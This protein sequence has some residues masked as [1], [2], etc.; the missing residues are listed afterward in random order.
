[1]NRIEIAGV[2]G[3]ILVVV[4]VAGGFTAGPER[5]AVIGFGLGLAFDLLLSTPLGLTALVYTAVGYVAGL[6]ATALIR[7]TKL[8]V[9][10]LATLAAPMA[11]FIWVVVGAL[12][13]QTHLFEGPLLAIA[14]VGAVVAFAS[15]WLIAPA[16]Q[17]A[18]FDLDRQVRRY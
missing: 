12:F 6:V 18:T 9:V 15:V 7:T 10:A 2:T 17:W 5:G 16:M 3:N 4:A 14:V 11:M 8:A 1:M 13:G